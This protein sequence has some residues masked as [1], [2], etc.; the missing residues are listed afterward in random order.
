MSKEM[1]EHAINRL[2]NWLIVFAFIVAFGVFGEFAFGWILRNRHRDLK[3][4]QDGEELT[5]LNRIEQLQRDTALANERAAQANKETEELR[6]LNLEL[7]KQITDWSIGNPTSFFMA[8]RK[9]RQPLFIAHVND[10]NARRFANEISAVLSR[11]GWDVT[12]TEVPDG[13]VGITAWND[14]GNNPLAQ[15]A[16]RLRAAL[17]SRGLPVNMRP[18]P[19][20]VRERSAGKVGVI[21]GKKPEPEQAAIDE[22]SYRLS[23]METEE[24]AEELRRIKA[25]LIQEFIKAK[26]RRPEPE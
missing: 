17:F 11:G 21:I 7:K 8:V 26:G 15:C 23:E 25:K 14:G 18:P 20:S 3:H 12:S 2:D 13:F 16:E 10:P 5:L 4:W 1:L 22:M 6:K 19:E 24:D 9:M